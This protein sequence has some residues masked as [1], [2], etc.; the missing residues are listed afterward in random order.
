MVKNDFSSRLH[1]T[2]TMAVQ[3]DDNDTADPLCIKG[4]GK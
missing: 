1:Y 2:Y 3:P 4:K